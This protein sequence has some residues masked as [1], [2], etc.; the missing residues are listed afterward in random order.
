MLLFFFLNGFSLWA[1]QVAISD[2]ALLP[3]PG[4]KL[5]LEEARAKTTEFQDQTDTRINKGFI[6]GAVWLRL[7]AQNFN[8]DE[9]RRLLVIRYPHID[10]IRLY[11]PDGQEQRVGDRR[12]FY[13]RVFRTRY[14]NLEM[15]LPPGESVWYLRAVSDG[16][17]LLPLEMTDAATLQTEDH[18]EQI[19]LGIYFGVLL[20]MVLY[21]LFLFFSLRS[22]T[23]LYYVLFI[24]SF[25]LFQASLNGTSFE[26]L[27]PEAI[28]W[29]NRS[30]STFVGL[31]TL[32]GVLFSRRYLMI[33]DYSR[34]LDYG[35]LAV[36]A[37]AGIISLAS[38][39]LSYALT[40]RIATVT[41]G[42]FA[43]VAI[44]AGAYA[45]WRGYRPARFFLIAWA[46]FFAGGLALSLKNYGILP[47][48]F[49]THYGIQIGSALEVILLSL[50]LADRINVLQSERDAAEK[51]KIES[52]LRMLDSFTRFVP[53]QFIQALGKSSIETVE[54]GNASRQEL[55]IL[56]NDI[57]NF[58]SL[59]ESMD[60]QENINFLNSY[61]RRM[62]P[63]IREAGGF[64]DKF[65]G[66]AI[67]ALFPAGADSAARSALK[68][69]EALERYNQH[70]SQLNYPPLTMGVGLHAG[71]VMLGTV[72]S[73]T[74][75][76]T[77]VI[78]DAV[79]VA[80]RIEQITKIYKLPVLA[81]RHFVESLTDSTIG[82]R[83]IDLVR[84]KGKSDPTA[85]YQIVD[86]DT[87]AGENV[88]NNQNHFQAGRDL[89]KEG[90]FAD[91]L[92]VFQ[93][94]AEKDP[95]ARL[96]AK[97][98]ERL[99]ENPPPSMENWRGV[100]KIRLG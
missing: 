20:V 59:S 41:G 64:I 24:L 50:G 29:Q 66:D 94:L 37:L 63:E 70:R 31:F 87:P 56:F 28:W 82:F 57:R 86:P 100:S 22:A 54:L 21:N 72:G 89:Y 58:T 46:F 16:P 88:L 35:L 96:M 26:Y 95:V 13:P 11:G 34:W 83:E 62:E 61:L 73:E 45:L 7:T 53:A 90:K 44:I 98:C 43:L 65:I 2:I 49:F 67:M 85:I 52:R 23:Y 81:S 69:N 38:F 14:L 47:E 92:R 71:E 93:E 48:N 84:L 8:A 55:A 60:V 36:G 51:E 79:N 6:E 3:D 40:I 18:N 19:A 42:V 68:M 4:G 10:E 91:A 30:V 80:A 17:M 97:R 74:R 75:L 77:T 1:G 78:G 25:L 99:L 15:K 76:D 32:F 39:L 33:R 9:K 12:P 27:W 5:S